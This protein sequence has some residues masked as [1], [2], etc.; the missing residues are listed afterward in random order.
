MS[1]IKILLQSFKTTKKLR[2]D[3]NSSI[4]TRDLDA[5]EHHRLSSSKE[6][7]PLYSAQVGSGQVRSEAVGRRIQKDICF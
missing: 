5:L 4:T 6:L 3:T 7:A 1:A 2:S